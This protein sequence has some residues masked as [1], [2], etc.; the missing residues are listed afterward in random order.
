[1]IDLIQ[2]LLSR[3]RLPGVIMNALCPLDAKCCWLITWVL[4]NATR[5]PCHV[6]RLFLLKN[7]LSKLLSLVYL[8]LQLEKT[9]KHVFP[10]AHLHWLDRSFGSYVSLSSTFK[11]YH[12]GCSGESNY[13]TA[14][15]SRALRIITLLSHH[16]SQ[17]HECANLLI[18]SQNVIRKSVL[19]LYG[20]P[21]GHT[22]SS[23]SLANLGLPHPI[24][25]PSRSLSTKIW[26]AQIIYH[27][28]V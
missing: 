11:S 14:C 25:L 3:K 19:C 28:S 17:P 10:A 12:Q 22:H 16:P 24:T 13:P 6:P 15:S 7:T 20:A 8:L 21:H 4:L 2:Q 5:F 23:Q 26:W 9:G 18:C 1:M 27:S